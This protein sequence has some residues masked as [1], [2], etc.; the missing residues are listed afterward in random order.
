MKG[1]SD[2][3]A[4]PKPL[5]KPKP[6]P[7]RIQI[8]LARE[9]VGAALEREAKARNMSLSQAASAILERGLRGKIEADA[10]NRLLAL[11]RR[12]AEQG[13]TT[14]RDLIIIEEML[15]IAL[16]TLFSRIPESPE[17]RD[18]AYQGSVDVLMSHAINEVAERLRLTRLGRE[19]TKTGEPASIRAAADAKELESAKTTPANDLAGDLVL[20]ASDSP[21]S[22]SEV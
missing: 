4:K 15:F 9:E 3:G 14:G 2:M 1:T 5:A 19:V 10:D 21:P 20:P 18:P 16:R 17:E 7:T 13:R 8:Y 22:V 6:G 12:V 11:E